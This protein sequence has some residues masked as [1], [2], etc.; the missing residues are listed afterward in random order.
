LVLIVAL[1]VGP[2]RAAGN[3]T[4]RVGLAD[5]SV[6]VTAQPNPAPAGSVFGY[7]S[8]I[9]NRGTFVAEG[10]RVTIEIPASS[11]SAEA[12]SQSC[13]IGGA[14]R[15]ER[16]GSGRDEPWVVTCDL[17][18]LPPNAETRITLAV[19]AGV[20]GTQMSVVTVSSNRPGA[21][22][23]DVRIETPVLVLPD[24]PEFIPAFQRPGR[25]NPLGR[26]TT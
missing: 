7:E 12:A 3:T 4:P 24:A 21:E 5:L 14:T 11:V 8:L 25:A 26:T 2:S 20:P 16:D 1:V 10:V 15:I 22:N 13:T 17:G 19:T 9:R 23:S 18:T 6:E